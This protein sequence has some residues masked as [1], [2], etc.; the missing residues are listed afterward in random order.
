MQALLWSWL[1]LHCIN[2]NSLS[3]FLVRSVLWVSS[4]TAHAEQMAKVGES[5]WKKGF[6]GDGF[7]IIH[8][9]FL[10]LTLKITLGHDGKRPDFKKQDLTQG[11]ISWNHM[12]KDS[13]RKKS[14]LL[15]RA[16]GL[17][18]CCPRLQWECR[19]ITL[20]P[21]CARHLRLFSHASEISI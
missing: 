7:Y 11:Q 18:L 8:L 19:K 12:D 9:P 20:N 10:W 2:L 17:L 21:F 1:L 6:E 14:V 13:R 4:A 16:Q 15:A 5:T 3:N